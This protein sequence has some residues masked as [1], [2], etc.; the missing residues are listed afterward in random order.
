[1]QNISFSAEKNAAF[2][3]TLKKRVNEYFK[4]NH[5]KK[6]G[7]Y[8]MYLKAAFMLS[9]YLT[10]YFFVLFGNIENKLIYFGLWIIMGFGMAGIGLSIMH[11]AN[12]GVFSS[13]PTVNKIMGGMIY[14]VGGNALNWK[15]Q[16]NVLH[17]TYT[18]VHGYDQDINSPAS[19]FRFSPHQELAKVHRYQF[20]YAWFF[21]SLLTITWAFNADFRQIYDFKKDGLTKISKKSFG[22][23]LFDLIFF[24]LL[25][26]GFIFALPLWLS[27]QPWWAT[28]LGFLFMQLVA[29][30][31][32]SCIFQ[33]AHVV[34][35]SD[36]PLPNDEG[37]L[38]NSWFVHQLHT[39]ADFSKKDKIFTWFAGGLNFQV[40]HHL[41]PNICHIHYSKISKIVKKTAE[42][43]QI[44]YHAYSSFW[45][46]LGGHIALLKRLGRANNRLM[47]ITVF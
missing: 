15:I 41:F 5:I 26:Y 46:A 28:L 1:M 32:L 45:S 9:L 20:I 13:H 8:T 42:E 27:S 2:T 24:K 18:N 34:P 37:Q 40:E 35:S 31:M 22:R 47:S 12:H 10:P 30:L 44:P 3:Q 39:T 43:Y 33:L 6:T 29:G 17:H 7:N 36:F 23:I 16:H 19:L 4:A 11:D 38:E 14:M 25:Y 21:Y